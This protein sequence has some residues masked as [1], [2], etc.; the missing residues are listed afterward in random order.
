MGRF[1]APRICGPEQWQAHLIR[2][3]SASFSF[4]KRSRSSRSFSYVLRSVSSL[5]FAAKSSLASLSRSFF[6][7]SSSDATG[8]RAFRRAANASGC[9]VPFEAFAGE[10]RMEDPLVTT[11]IVDEGAAK[12]FFW[13]A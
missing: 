2:F 5:R 13:M 6:A 12:R 10:D 7:L 3:L 8:L 9:D 1:S 4:C 11:G